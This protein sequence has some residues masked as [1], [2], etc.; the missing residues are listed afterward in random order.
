MDIRGG[1]IFGYSWT[2]VGVPAA[3]LGLCIYYLGWKGQE[4]LIAAPP[5]ASSDTTGR[6]MASSPLLSGEIP[7]LHH[8]S[9]TQQGG[10]GA[11]YYCLLRA[12][13]QAPHVISADTQGWLGLVT[14]QQGESPSSLL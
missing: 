3:P 7:T 14:V 9:D 11:P 4:C 13:V 2:G 8:S 12:G 1:K 5:V 6:E 10:E